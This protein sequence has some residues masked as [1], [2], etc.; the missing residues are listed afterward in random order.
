MAD[1][2]VPSASSDLSTLTGRV[3]LPAELARAPGLKRLDWILSLPE[4]AAF[5]GA[6]APQELYAWLCDIG[7]DDAYPLLE[8]ADAEQ[9]RGLVDLDA[10]D[11]NALQLPRVLEWLDLARAVDLETAQRFIAAQ[12]DELF[13]WLFTDGV[14]VLPAD[15]DLDFIPDDRA[16]FHTPDRMYVITVPRGHALEDRVPQLVELMWSADM[17]RSRTLL[18]Q[19]QFELRSANEEELLRFRNA[20]LTELGFEP[21]I[22]ALSVYAYEPPIAAR[23]AVHADLKTA[24]PAFGR[25]PSPLLT[26]QATD[27]TLRG[28]TAPDLLR[29]AILALPEADRLRTGDALAALANKVF[30]ADVGDLSRVDD[31]PLTSARAVAIANLGLAWLADE[32]VDVA[33]EI[34][35]RRNPE[36]AFR[37]GHSLITGLV[38]RA[39][40]LGRRA[41]VLLDFHVFGPPIDDLLDGLLMPRPLFPEAL[42]D[43]GRVGWR[44]FTTPAD[45]ALAETHLR[46]GDETLTWFETAFGFSPEALGAISGLSDDERRRVRLDTLFRT[47][48]AHALLHDR[49]SFEPLAADA[50]RAFARLAFTADGAASPALSVVRSQAEGAPAGVRSFVDRA[51]AT[52][53]DALAGILPSDLDPRYASE[54]LLVRRESSASTDSGPTV[55]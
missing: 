55:H 1:P 54:L 2:A 29:A 15:T 51:L 13:L 24:P 7:K 35:R 5:V 47:A 3:Q 27:L 6:L 14:E 50:V 32:S 43:E 41:G 46:E 18:Q 26:H 22:E 23:E 49:V 30:M 16:L 9:L 52:L 34:L 4:P 40:P 11:K 44:A 10:W 31:L 20:R 28:V 17:A 48:V 42:D 36:F 12:D 53:T 39:R 38:R 8:Y 33:V 45:L 21:P 25:A 19:A 37:V